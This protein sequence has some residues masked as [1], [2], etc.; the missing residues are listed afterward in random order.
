VIGIDG[1]DRVRLL[2]A[3]YDF[4]TAEEKNYCK[5]SLIMF[6]HKRVHRDITEEKPP[7]F[8]YRLTLNFNRMVAGVHH[9][10]NRKYLQNYLDEYCYKFSRRFASGD[11]FR[12]FIKDA[13][14]QEPFL[15]GY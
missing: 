13:V 10:V 15:R 6:H 8:T 3:Q 7:L 14:L 12:R 9:L 11:L 5:L 4:D 1:S 2:S